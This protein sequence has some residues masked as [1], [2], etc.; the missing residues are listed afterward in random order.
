MRSNLLLF[1]ITISLF[2]SQ[3]V[4]AQDETATSQPL[5]GQYKQLLE[6]TESFK[7][8]KV[9]KKKQLNAFWSIVEDSLANYKRQI[10]ETQ[11]TVTAQKAE[12]DKQATEIDEK[13]T[14]LSQG[15]YEKKHIAVLGIDF[16]KSAYVVTSFIIYLVLA[17]GLA[18]I[19]ISF[20]RS[21]KLTQQSKKEF[22]DLEKEYNGYKQKALDKQIKMG[23][24][25]QT[26]NNKVEELKQGQKSRPAI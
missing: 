5:S 1:I 7:D 15:D 24:E 6:D 17:G 12:I 4:Q 26:L 16:T 23:R 19:I 3:A 2:F 10:G 13:N 25:L 11:Q 20:L 18:F 21:N 9:I 14:L 22:S 8:Y